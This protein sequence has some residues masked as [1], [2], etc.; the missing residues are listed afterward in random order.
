MPVTSPSPTRTS[1]PAPASAARP[2]GAPA[3]RFDRTA[4]LRALGVGI[5]VAI[6]LAAAVGA[7][8]SAAGALPAEALAYYVVGVGAALF[9]AML[10]VWLHGRF[11]TTTAAGGRSPA[12]RL[13][14]LLAAA[15]AVK[16][17]VLVLGFVLLRQFPLAEAADGGAKFAW[18]ATFAVTFAGSAL[19]CQLATAGALARALRR[20]PEAAR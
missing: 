18:L 5:A 15:F 13:Q 12:S 11:A 8:L 20:R 6:A 1:T 2:G 10:T 16:L 19:A 3:V 9:A 17:G 14:S 4:L 7:A